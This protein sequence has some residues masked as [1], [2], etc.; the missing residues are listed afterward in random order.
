MNCGYSSR[1]SSILRSRTFAVGPRSAFTA[2]NSLSVSLKS[3]ARVSLER[4]IPVPPPMTSFPST[5]STGYFFL[6]FGRES[7]SSNPRRACGLR[8]AVSRPGRRRLEFGE[9]VGPSGGVVHAE[10]LGVVLVHPE[11][12]V[13][14]LPVLAEGRDDAGRL[15][16]PVMRPI[17]SGSLPRSQR[18][19]SVPWAARRSHCPGSRRGSPGWNR[20]GC[21]PGPRTPR[22]ARC[23]PS[24]PRP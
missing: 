19:R 12:G 10:D 24:G 3:S 2:R 4:Y 1:M 21:R 11:D 17:S 14:L 20:A 5:P 6:P 7:L 15:L 8:R 18:R 16:D 9:R 23:R 22:R 13:K